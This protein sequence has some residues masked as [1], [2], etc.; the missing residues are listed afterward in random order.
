MKQV[1]VSAAKTAG[2]AFAALVIMAALGIA[3]SRLLSPY[4]DAHRMEI[5]QWASELL[6]APIHIESARIS[7]YEYQPGV[8]LQNVTM[9]DKKTNQPV[10]QVKTVNVFFSLLSSLQQR[11]PV[12]S[13]ILIQGSDLDIEKNKNGEYTVKAFANLLNTANTE[14]AESKVMDVLG[15]LSLQPMIVLHE[16]DV[17]YT[18]PLGQLRYYTL[19]ELHLQ[20]TGTTH[21]LVGGAVLHQEIPTELSVAA[22]AEGTVENWQALT[23]KIFIEVRGLSLREWLQGLT[24]HGYSVKQGLMTA[25]VWASYRDNALQNVQSTFELLNLDIV[26]P[27]KIPLETI[28]RLSGQL[29]W[30]KENDYQVIAGNELLIDWETRLWPATSFYLKLTQN[31]NS[32]WMPAVLNMGY[33]NLG[34]LRKMAKS[35]PDLL[36]KNTMTTLDALDLTGNIENLSAV[37]PAESD[38]LIPNLIQGRFSNISFKTLTKGTALYNLAGAFKWM[39]HQGSVTFNGKN[40]A[41]RD[42]AVFLQPLEFVQLTGTVSWQESAERAWRIQC[43]QLQVLNRDITANVSGTL[44][45]DAAMK[46]TLNINGHFSLVN[47]VNISHYLPVKV[48]SKKLGGWL[49]KAFL[50][51]SVKDAN[52]KINGNLNDFPFDKHNGEFVIDSMVQN[53]QLH[54][55]PDWP[56]LTNINGK[57]MFSGRQILIDVDNAKILNMNM[58]NVKAEIPYLGDAKPSVLTATAPQVATDFMQAL[59]FLHQTPL[60]QTIGK[61]FSKLEMKGAVNLSLTLVVPLENT[62]NI[63]VSGN[64]DFSNATMQLA[65]WKLDITSLAGQ[66]HFTEDATDARSVAGEL[67][68]KPLRLDLKSIK[69]PQGHN[70]VQATVTNTLDLHDIENW[71]HVSFAS[72]ASGATNVETRIDLAVDE[73]INIQMSS[74][75]IGI[76]LNLPDGYGKAENDSREF[77]ATMKIAEHQPLNVNLK[78]AQLLSAAMELEQSKNQFKLLT[79]NLNLGNG[80]AIL[81]KEHGLFITGEIPALDEERIKTY[82]GYSKGSGGGLA[83]KNIDV[84]IDKISLYGMNINQAKVGLKPLPAAWQLNVDSGEISGEITIPHEINASSKVIADLKHINLDALRGSTASSMEITAKTLPSIDFSTNS[85]TF[86]GMQIGAVHVDTVPVKS[87]LLINH[88]AVRSPDIKLDATGAWEQT[89]KSNMTTLHGRAV[90]SNIS[91]LFTSLGFDAHNFVATTGTVDFNLNWHAT[92]ANLSLSTLSGD[93]KI[94]LDKG[95]IVSVNDSSNAK[96][97]FG[98]M[99]NLFSLQNIPRRLSFDFSD[100]FE[101]GYSFDYLRA[102]FDFNNGNATTHNMVFDGTL[103]KVEIRGRIG[104]AKQDFDLILSVTPYVTSSIPVA[105]TLLTGQPVIG[106][107]AWA[108]NKMIGG[109]LSK[110]VTYYYS[111]S[112][113]WSKLEWNMIQKSQA[114]QAAG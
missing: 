3:G 81:P 36:P 46:P 114:N 12:M 108:V 83:L 34:D 14:P 42:D 80:E 59:N 58:G 99:L 37:F 40:V 27:A 56:D 18:N 82:L 85:L 103:A 57:L 63:K 77:N 86:G 50:A 22:D 100:V 96:M 45:L 23:A 61:M 11:K 54:Y 29:G 31:K 92:P 102:D 65:P 39:E 88:F 93:A 30:K 94:N 2:Y 72:T 84:R 89:S 49:S 19:H 41:L 73:P 28:T 97:D 16:I 8:A 38:S 67:F 87:G 9:L 15:W 75:L 4:L 66:V 13:G 107:A 106:I 111:V 51:G 109:E 105:A 10:F 24:Y 32:Q 52:I 112:G 110:A 95:R 113:T 98:R 76:K 44:Q 101:K 1:L 64:L 7:W 74:N 104:L 60:Q 70:V 48:F 55:A 20:N 90:S 5:E 91:A 26:T 68:G 47:A 33:V 62:D 35:T 43:Q 25:R 21:H 78:Y 6:H 53:I 69:D 17:H 79:L 71:L